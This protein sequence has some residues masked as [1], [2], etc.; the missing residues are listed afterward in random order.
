[1]LEWIK[2]KIRDHF[3]FSRAETYGVLLLTCLMILF[4]FVPSTV[5]WYYRKTHTLDCQADVDMLDSIIAELEQQRI[6]LSTYA[7][8]STD[9]HAKLQ[10]DTQKAAP[11]SVSIQPFDINMADAEQLQQIS[12]IGSVLSVRIIKYRGQLGG[13]VSKEQYTEVYGLSPVGVKG[14]TSRTYVAASFKPKQLDIN[15]ASFQALIRHPYL[16]YEQVKALIR[17][18]EKQGDFAEVTDL[19]KFKI[20]DEDAFERVRP[21]LKIE[22]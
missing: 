19:I 10:E 6:V 9:R 13:F 15:T 7:I 8:N 12:G 4:L 20:L 5:S 16:D 3:G 21:Y 22:K 17:H 14:L 1:M 18:R 2:H 11:K